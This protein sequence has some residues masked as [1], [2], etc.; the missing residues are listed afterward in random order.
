MFNPN[1]KLRKLLVLPITW[2]VLV[3][4]FLAYDLYVVR[5]Q[6][7]FLKESGF[8]AL[9]A[10]CDEVNARFARAQASSVSSVMLVSIHGKDIQD[11]LD[12][13]LNLY[14]KGLS[15]HQGSSKSAAEIK[16][17]RTTDKAPVS[18]RAVLQDELILSVSCLTKPNP[19]LPSNKDF[20]EI[21]KLNLEPWVREAAA[22]EFGSY[23]DDVLITDTKGRVLFQRSATGPRI[24]DIQFILPN[25]ESGTKPV[26]SETSSGSSAAQQHEQVQAGNSNT[27]PVRDQDA[28]DLFQFRK[29]NSSSVFT[30]IDLA[31]RKYQLFSQPK[32]IALRG[33]VANLVV[34]GLRNKADFDSESH[35]LPYSIVIWGA[36][37]TVALFSSSWPLFKL[38]Y[39]SNT[40]RFRPRDGWYLILAIFLVSTSVTLI[41][42]NGSYISQAQRLVDGDMRKLA[43]EIRGH[44]SEEI[45]RAFQQLLDIRDHE[46]KKIQKTFH[47]SSAP[48]VSGKYLN[49]RSTPQ[50]LTY[51]YFEI[52]FWTDCKGEQ[53]IKF[54]VRK[55]P[56]PPINVATFAFFKNLVPNA[57]RLDR[58]CESRSTKHSVDVPGIDS[59]NQAYLEP[60]L[61][62]NTKEF[63][64][65][66]SAPF[67]PSG[68][69]QALT[70]KLMSLVDPVL[71]P[72]YGFAV[73]DAE[74]EV[75]FHSHSLRNKKENFCRESKDKGELKPWLMAGVDAPLNI[76]YAG[77]TARA[78]VTALPFPGLSA[79]Q[80]FLIVFQEPNRQMTRNMAIILVCSILFG[81]YFAIPLLVAALH[82]SL[83]GPL[84]LVYAPILLWPR[85]K[86]GLTYAQLFCANTLILLLFWI[87]YHLLYEA[88]LLALTLLV[89]VVSIVSAVLK[90]SS[91]SRALFRIGCALT[92]VALL[93]LCGFSL[94]SLYM[95]EEW[96]ILFF[97]LVIYGLVL[98]LLSGEFPQRNDPPAPFRLREGV[99]KVALAHFSVTYVLAAATLVTCIAVIPCVGFF[100]YAYDAVHEI[101]LKHDQLILSERLLARKNRIREYY[102][103]VLAPPEIAQKRIRETFDRYD[104][105]FF[106]VT[107]EPDLP[108]DAPPLDPN[109]VRTCV[110]AEFPKRG[111]ND[112]IE[113]RVAQA[114]LTFPENQ[115]GREMSKLG[116][117]STDDAGLS[118]E[119]SRRR[120][121]P[122]S[123]CSGKLYLDCQI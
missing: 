80:T 75:L 42:L 79:G 46:K 14:L 67:A 35:S 64:P 41:L 87:F 97:V 114:T 57:N 6:E 38:H 110:G 3:A 108:D 12:S 72:G 27:R 19:Q 76:S 45:R 101:S 28:E 56:T 40:E 13:Y 90:L 106:T 66:L 86:K 93:G 20:L 34:C 8:R 118:W 5:N 116:V 94:I 99:K 105:A 107:C 73:V 44:F 37:I 96:K 119:R 59:L 31:G 91:F 88:P 29:L 60:L 109:S 51:P 26:A 115:L 54:D 7:Q 103:S 39:M 100:K 81:I 122:F 50:D 113:R 36:L 117:A 18:L 95:V 22:E 111:L 98:M 43:A 53:R 77:R 21:Y 89:P 33:S 104:K 24:T 47:A 48:I 102:E 83:R 112:W 120:V 32:P 82:L 62:P 52:A 123:Y 49:L 121:Q 74:C 71:P 10:I 55:A 68:G 84:N 61:S 70:T 78:Y 2:A 15:I 85:Q 9:A 58:S 4:L 23:F 17:C 1:T 11:L 92:F 30:E 16:T 25:T 69:I 63:S 65:V